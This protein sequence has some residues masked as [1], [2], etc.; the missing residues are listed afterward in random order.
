MVEPCL[1]CVV[2]RRC[3]KALGYKNNQLLN[4]SLLK[5][6]KLQNESTAKRF[7]E[8]TTVTLP[9]LF[10]ISNNCQVAPGADDKVDLRVAVVIF[11]VHKIADGG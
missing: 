2:K 4:G 1:L 5:G 9:I 3:S 10:A 11:F 7:F 6:P 8:Q